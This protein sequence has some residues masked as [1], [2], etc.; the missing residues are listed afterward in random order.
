MNLPSHPQHHLYW[1]LPCAVFAVPWTPVIAAAGGA[2]EIA[3]YDD[4]ISSLSHEHYA[5]CLQW[6]HYQ[7]YVVR[8]IK[9]QPAIT[10]VSFTCCLIKLPDLKRLLPLLLLAQATL[11]I[12]WLFLWQILSVLVGASLVGQAHTRMSIASSPSTYYYC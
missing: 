3:V 4:V 2:G 1:D 11:A 10:G 12:C 6:L 7:Y 8:I 9:H 5:V